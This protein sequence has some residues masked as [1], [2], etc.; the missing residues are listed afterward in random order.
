MLKLSN[1][2]CI[3]YLNSLTFESVFLRIYILQDQLS[4]KT[5]AY[6]EYVDM[7]R[8]SQSQKAAVEDEKRKLEVSAL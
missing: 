4:K 3:H 1:P 7:L 5:A 8:S 6:N 2:S